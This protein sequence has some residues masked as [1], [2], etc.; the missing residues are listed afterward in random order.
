METKTNAPTEI[1][2]TQLD[3]VAAG[4]NMNKL[5][6]DPCL[7][8]AAGGTD[9]D[10]FTLNGGTLSGARASSGHYTQVVWA[11]T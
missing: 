2:D 7:E 11:K 6:W 3:D 9:R 4:T 1:A 8:Q 10:N 5:V